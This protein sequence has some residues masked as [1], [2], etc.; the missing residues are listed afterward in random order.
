MRTNIHPLGA[1]ALNLKLTRYPILA[2]DGLIFLGHEGKIGFPSSK[3][4]LI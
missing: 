4:N 2:R 3:N 1:D